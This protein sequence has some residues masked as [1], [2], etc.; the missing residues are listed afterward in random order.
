MGFQKTERALGK[1]EDVLTRFD[2]YADVLVATHASIPAGLAAERRLSAEIG[3]AE[4]AGADANGLKSK[5]A[6]ATREREAAVLRRSAAADGVLKLESELRNA[7]EGIDRERQALSAEVAREF[8]A[9]YSDAVSRLQQLWSEGDALGRALNMAVVMPMPVKVTAS[10]LDGSR[11]SNRFPP[12]VLRSCCR[13]IWRALWICPQGSTPRS[14]V[15]LPFVARG[16][17][18]RDFTGRRRFGV[19]ARNTRRPIVWFGSS[20]ITKTAKC[21]R[22]ELW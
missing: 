3:A 18:T 20:T 1:A 4:V 15:A 2:R 17:P 11:V 7:R 6:S 13:R 12:R 8:Q 21:S 16:R 22:R 19:K 14:R 9:R 10:L 5:L